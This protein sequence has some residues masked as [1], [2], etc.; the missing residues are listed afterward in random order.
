[1]VINFDWKI[2][3]DIGFVILLSYWFV[4]GSL[5]FFDGTL[6][7]YNRAAN[8]W[9]SFID[10]SI[11]GNHMWKP[12]YDPEGF[13]SIF[14]SIVTCLIRV[15]IARALDTMKSINFLFYSAFPLIFSG[16]LLGFWFLIIKAIWSSSF[17]L[18]TSGIGTFIL[19]TIYYRYK[20]MPFGK[21]CKYE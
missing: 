13:L 2:L 3:L 6:P 7:A 16:C 4:L 17:V 10:S 8:N 1:L 11:L 9:V 12:D 21:V 14:P 19:A 5:S 20:K 15:L 18:V